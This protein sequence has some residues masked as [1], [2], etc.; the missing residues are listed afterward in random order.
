MDRAY[1]GFNGFGSKKAL[2]LITTIERFD[3]V[4]AETGLHRPVY[5][6]H[7]FFKYH[8]VEG[9]YHLASTKFTKIAATLARRAFRMTLC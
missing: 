9:F 5:F 7:V 8:I 1:F 6:E 2:V 4:V 3:K